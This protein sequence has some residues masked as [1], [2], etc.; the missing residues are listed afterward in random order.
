[1]MRA[2]SCVVLLAFAACD[3]PSVPCPSGGEALGTSPTP[4]A[5]YDRSC[6]GNQP[7]LQCNRV[8]VTGSVGDIATAGLLG[9]D[10]T[11]TIEAIDETG[12]QLARTRTD[13]NGRYS[14]QIPVGPDGFRGYVPASAPGTWSHGGAWSVLS[15]RASVTG[16]SPA[17]GSTEAINQFVSSFPSLSLPKI[18]PAKG[19]ATVVPLD[20]AGKRMFGLTV[21]IDRPYET[22][23]YGAVAMPK[24]GVA[25]TAE[26][27]PFVAFLNIDPGPVVVTLTRAST[28]EVVGHGRGTIKA[29]DWPAMVA[30]PD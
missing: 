18:N 19:N 24:G 20:C 2:V 16:A 5:D 3:A 8:T 15:L 29:M 6:I 13:L 21:D 1:M 28:G 4:G 12:R 22:R 30:G 17:I 10:D 11:A 26:A 7:K 14:I 27:A 23:I 25:E 9:W